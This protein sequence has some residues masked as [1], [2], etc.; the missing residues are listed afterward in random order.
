MRFVSLC[1]FLCFFSHTLAQC[2]LYCEEE[3]SYFTYQLKDGDIVVNDEGET[4]DGAADPNDVIQD[5][6]IVN[7][8]DGVF[9][10]LEATEGKKGPNAQIGWTE[11][12]KTY[13]LTYLDDYFHN[14]R[15]RYTCKGW[16]TRADIAYGNT[17]DKYNII[18]ECSEGFTE[19]WLVVNEASSRHA[20]IGLLATAVALVATTMW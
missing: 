9:V 12:N 6:G 17:C 16:N 5:K 4:A 3:F 20:S 2:D 15:F 1:L 13:C 7:A 14:P 18:G 19:Y 11:V 10:T 8:I